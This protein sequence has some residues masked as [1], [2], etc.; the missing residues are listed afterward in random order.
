M[1]SIF[2]DI[3]Y[4]HVAAAALA[5]RLVNF[6]D[7]TMSGTDS[8]A[9]AISSHNKNFGHGDEAGNHF[10][11]LPRHFIH[12]NCLD[13]ASEHE[14]DVQNHQ[15][16]NYNRRRRR[17]RQ[18]GVGESLRYAL[19]TVLLGL[20]DEIFQQQALVPPYKLDNTDQGK[21]NYSLR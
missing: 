19:E 11:T 17:R 7:V 6:R 5:L 18:D 12:G 3:E 16:G 20:L 14:Q 21:T 8:E 1:L 4:R 10:D 15:Q 9:V 2:D 13:V